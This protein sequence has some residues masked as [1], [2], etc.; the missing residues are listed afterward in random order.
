[1]N[2]QSGASVRPIVTGDIKDY[3]SGFS[4]RL[5]ADE[6]ILFGRRD[7]PVKKLI[8]CWM[9]ETDAIAYALSQQA[10]TILCHEIL[11]YPSDV[12]H[13]SS[14]PEF[15]SWPV[16]H[17]RASMLAQGGITLIR[18]HMTV[19][20]VCIL[21][22]FAAKLGL[23]EPVCKKPDLVMAYRGGRTVADY[24]NLVK[25]TFG[26]RYVR[27]T[28]RDLGRI[29]QRIGLPWGGLGISRNVRY[30]EQLA[31]LGCDLFIAG[32]TENYAMRFARDS[33]IDM[34]ETGHELSENPGLKHFADMLSGSFPQ[35][36]VIFYEN[37]QAFSYY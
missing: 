22:D 6:G 28:A 8:V 32:E 13:A 15:L 20:R 4:G 23:G 2:V 27:H 10:D 34:I 14:A 1:M 37:P 7:R 11:F 17:A 29:V 35:L 19:D 33:G 12:L 30:M 26:M 18:G 25:T 24:L 36:E 9:A 3:L 21:D 16:N 5:D 31:E